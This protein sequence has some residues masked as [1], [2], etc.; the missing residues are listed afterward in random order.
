MY[1]TNTG[2]LRRKVGLTVKTEPVTL[3]ISDWHSTCEHDS[4]QKNDVNV[5]VVTNG[6]QICCSGVSECI[7]EENVI[8]I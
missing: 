8:I 6:T 7:S 4:N 3:R 5:C 1:G 2:L